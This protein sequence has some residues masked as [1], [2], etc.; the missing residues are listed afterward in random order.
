[1]SILTTVLQESSLAE[2]ADSVNIRKG[3]VANHGMLGTVK[4]LYINDTVAEVV[5]RFGKHIK[6][7][8]S[9]LRP[10]EATDE[11]VTENYDKHSAAANNYDHEIENGAKDRATYKDAA[12]HHE[13]AAKTAPSDSLKKVHEK[14]AADYLE[15]ARTTNEATDIAGLNIGDPVIVTGQ[16]VGQGETGTLVDYGAGGRFVVIRM[17]DGSKRSYHSSDIEYYDDDMDECMNESKTILSEALEQISEWGERERYADADWTSAPARSMASNRTGKYC[18]TRDNP[19]VRGRGFLCFGSEKDAI[20]AWKRLS[21]NTGVKIVRES[22]FNDDGTP[23]K[24]G[25]VLLV[26][27]LKEAVGDRYVDQL[28]AQLPPGLMD[29][30]DILGQAFEIAKQELGPK[31]ARYYF[32]YD[33]DFASDLVST[34]FQNERAG[35]MHEAAGDKKSA[36]APR[37]F[38]AKHAKM[39]GAGEH[40]DKKR[41]AKQ[42]DV[43]HKGKLEEESQSVA[44]GSIGM[45]KQKQDEKDKAEW[46]KNNPLM[47]GKNPVQ[48]QAAWAIYSTSRDANKGKLEESEDGYAKVE[49]AIAQHKRTLKNKLAT[50]ANVAYAQKMIARGNAALK[51]STGEEAYKHFQGSVKESVVDDLLALSEKL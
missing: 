38:V 15:K 13:R 45:E 2:F 32:A 42:G 34:Y 46:I 48:Q 18:L 12:K 41:A 4:V 5:D 26:D 7:Q 28:A 25:E 11:S 1:M 29:E 23:L 51:K 8:L 43:K 6:V 33:E 10:G 3:D 17:N 19:P 40:K 44:E 27:P 49:K 22:A 36:P 24:E 50:P 20:F 39:G 31:R 35:G 9:S 30:D 16:V 14:K 21:N 37:N 47:K